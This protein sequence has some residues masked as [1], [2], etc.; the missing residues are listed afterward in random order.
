MTSVG[1]AA[2][3]GVR[4]DHDLPRLVER[5]ARHVQY[6]G[7]ATQRSR[8]ARCARR[9]GWR[10]EGC[11]NVSPL[12]SHAVGCRFRSSALTEPAW[13]CVA[14]VLEAHHEVASELHTGCSTCGSAC[15]IR[16]STPRRDT[17]LTL[18]PV[19]LRNH[20][21][22]CRLR[23]VSPCGAT[24][25]RSATA[26]SAPSARLLDVEP[27]HTRCT[28]VGLDPLPRPLQALSRQRRLQQG[29]SLAFTA[30]PT[31][32]PGVHAAGR[33]LRHWQDHPRLD[34][35]LRPP[36]SLRPVLVH[37]L[38]ASLHASSPHS[39]TFMQLR[40]ASS[41]VI[42]L[43]QDGSRP[44]KRPRDA[45]PFERQEGRQAPVPCRV[46]YCTAPAGISI[47]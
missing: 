42:N 1:P 29:S 27:I 40:F 39:V 24:F 32:R 21:P 36:G 46:S 25:V 17:Q 6:R 47:M 44:K 30:L 33:R 8:T 35:A 37:R 38:A 3:L 11:P 23:P 15:W 45:G 43:R 5:L 9:S 41:A 12:R 19:R 28:L 22:S 31:L 7:G 4:G 20:H 26:S 18:A 16:R 10:L 14:L 34:R 13:S 2:A